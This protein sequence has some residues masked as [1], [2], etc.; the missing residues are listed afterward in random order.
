MLRN[1]CTIYRENKVPVLKNNCLWKAVIYKV[2]RSVAAS[3]L[4]LIK[5]I[6]FISTDF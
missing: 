4:T 3:L 6:R 5:A 2:L 1:K